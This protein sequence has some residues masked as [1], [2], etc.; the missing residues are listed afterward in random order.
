MEIAGSYGDE[1][2]LRNIKSGT[3]LDGV[4]RQLYRS[5]FL[6]ASIY[7]KQNSGNQEDAEDIFQEAIVNFIQLVQKN[8]FRG[9]CSIGTFIY[10]LVRHAWLN[11]LK[12]NKRTKAR[13]E[14][15]E[16]GKDLSEPDMSEYMITMESK[17][18][19]SKL[20][21]GLGETC[22]KILTAF[23]YENLSMQE[24]L[25]NLDYENEQVVRNKK[26]K[27]LQKLQENLASKPGL[28]KT[29]KSIL[30]YET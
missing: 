1:E 17:S 15:F 2:L 30:L 28:A 3:N 18:L 9:D 21:E 12:K 14:K 5:N 4:I 26:Y 6:K 27:C 22:K 19:I 11:E 13:E 7:I 25:L 29:L 16:S 10:T 23:Y 24:I 20:I 8:K